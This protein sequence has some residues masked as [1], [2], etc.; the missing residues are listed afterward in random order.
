MPRFDSTMIGRRPK[1]SDSTPNTGA[2]TNCMSANTVPKTPTTPAAAAMFSCMKPSTSGTNTGAITPSAMMSSATVMK[3][4]IS[5]PLRGARSAAFA[6][7]TLLGVGD[8]VE[9]CDP[10]VDGAVEAPAV[11][12]RQH[13][14]QEPAIAGQD[15]R[16][17]RARI[18]FGVTVAQ[19]ARFEIVEPHVDR[20]VEETRI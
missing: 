3:M 14:E 12:G 1:R 18:G 8:G 20:A 10:D 4:K 7:R 2:Q 9:R 16:C 13:V 19:G 17:D 11:A 15:H 6:T 5:A